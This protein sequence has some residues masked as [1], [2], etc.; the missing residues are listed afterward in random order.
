[1]IVSPPIVFLVCRTHQEQIYRVREIAFRISPR[2]FFSSLRSPDL[3]RQGLESPHPLGSLRLSV[4]AKSFVASATSIFLPEWL[5]RPVRPPHAWR[6]GPRFF[7]RFPTA[8]PGEV[9]FRRPWV[10][11]WIIVIGSRG[12]VRSAA[13]WAY[14]HQKPK[15]LAHAAT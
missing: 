1:M 5:V 2:A 8:L 15:M 11:W 10:R 14:R 13:V 12:G 7:T 6:L 3:D 9:Y 4:K